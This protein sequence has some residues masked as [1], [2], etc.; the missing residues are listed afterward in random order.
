MLMSRLKQTNTSLHDE[1]KR[2]FERSH[3]FY[4]ANCF[5]TDRCLFEQYADFTDMIFPIFEEIC[6]S[7]QIDVSNCS[8]Y[9]KRYVGFLSERLTSYWIYAMKKN[10]CAEVADIPMI[11][12]EI[13]NTENGTR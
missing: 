9:Q 7:G 1:V 5:I 8:N 6:R 4:I 3:E 11:N 2:Y 12:L 13:K 10:G